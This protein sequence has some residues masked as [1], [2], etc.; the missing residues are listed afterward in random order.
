MV[1]QAAR[2]AIKMKGAVTKKKTV[3]KAKRI[4]F[5]QSLARE[6]T[7]SRNK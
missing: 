4:W 7:L 5:Y 3:T 2:N 6:D 1:K